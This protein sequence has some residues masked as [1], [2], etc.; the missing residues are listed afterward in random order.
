MRL[1]ATAANTFGRLRAGAV[2]R[3]R[4]VRGDRRGYRDGGLHQ[5]LRA[6]ARPAPAC[7]LRSGTRGYFPSTYLNGH[8]LMAVQCQG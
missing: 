1:A 5:R 8:A 6:R 3:R 2:R 4:G 7:C